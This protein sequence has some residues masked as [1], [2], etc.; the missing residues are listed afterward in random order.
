MFFNLLTYD[1]GIQSRLRY[2]IKVNLQNKFKLFPSNSSVVRALS[3]KLSS[4]LHV[5]DTPNDK[6]D[7]LILN[8]ITQYF[9]QIF[10]LLI[11]VTVQK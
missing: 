10:C 8:K 11:E 2:P 6:F 7:L 5:S 4:D 1:P 3:C 9:S